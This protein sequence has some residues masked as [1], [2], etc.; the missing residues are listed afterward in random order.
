M[1][2]GDTIFAL[3]SAAGRAG[4]AVFRVSGPKAGDCVKRLTGQDIPPS[5]S[6]GGA[7]A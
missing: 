1:N 2:R 6:S 7:Q 5:H 4:V 3:A